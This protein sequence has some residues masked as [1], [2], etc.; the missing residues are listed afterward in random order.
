MIFLDDRYVLIQFYADYST[1][2]RTP[3]FLVENRKGSGVYEFYDR[4]Y[5]EILE[6]AEKLPVNQQ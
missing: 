6:R 5:Q 1:G 3:S 2:E 4:L